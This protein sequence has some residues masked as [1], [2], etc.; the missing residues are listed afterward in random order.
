M[1]LQ[2][3]VVENLISD[4]EFFD[5]N[6]Y[7]GNNKSLVFQNPEMESIIYDKSYYDH[8]KN[9]EKYEIC[10]NLNN[11]RYKLVN[12][13]K[14]KKIMDIGVGSGAFIQTC[15]KIQCFGYDINTFSKSW[16]CEKNIFLN[17]YED[18]TS[19]IDGWTMW[20]VLEH[21]RNP[22]LLLRK[23]KSKDYLFLSLPIYDNFSNLHT[24]K[25]FKLN[26]HFF[27]F[28]HDG[29]IDFI[30]R[31][32]FIFIHY[33]KKEIDLGRESIYRYVFTKK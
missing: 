16:L 3:V 12:Y 17:P 29:L 24:S 1:N 9:L 18:D 11:E 14:C 23:I 22:Y 2:K 27:Y 26:E 8:Y 10:K 15:E 20:D 7:F 33:D 31:Q 28:T 4:I 6:H 25:H 19:Y 13:F 30:C 5:D 21:L 32:D